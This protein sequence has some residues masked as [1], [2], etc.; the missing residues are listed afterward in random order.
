ML[1]TIPDFCTEQLI[2]RCS[3]AGKIAQRYISAVRY[4]HL[5]GVVLPCLQLGKKTILSVQFYFYL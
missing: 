4:T 1:N 2:Y 5:C 3:I